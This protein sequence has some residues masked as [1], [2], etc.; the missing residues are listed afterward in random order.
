MTGV[1]LVLV[2]RVYVLLRFRFPF[3]LRNLGV[4][5]NY[6]KIVIMSSSVEKYRLVLY[7][8]Y[9]KNLQLILNEMF[10]AYWKVFILD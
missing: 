8:T 2:L 7:K 4:V 6:W 1:R 10:H 3:D 9:I 5:L